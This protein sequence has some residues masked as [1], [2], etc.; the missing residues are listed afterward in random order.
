M[1]ARTC[2]SFLVPVARN[3]DFGPARRR[4]LARQSTSTGAAPSGMTRAPT[5]SDLAGGRLT[6]SKR[7]GFLCLP[8]APGMPRLRSRENAA[9]VRGWRLASGRGAQEP[10]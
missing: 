1:C 9:T 7:G 4:F 8:P 5:R 6:I 10:S 2:A 3:I